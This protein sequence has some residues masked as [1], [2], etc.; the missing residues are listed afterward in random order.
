[1]SIQVVWDDDSQGCVRY[2]IRGN[3]TMED[4]DG[5]RCD[6]D[7]LTGGQHVALMIII[8][9]RES[10][11]VPNGLFAHFGGRDY[12]FTEQLSLMVFVGAS[13]LVRTLASSYQRIYRK[14][15]VDWRFAG[16]LEEARELIHAYQEAKSSRLAARVTTPAR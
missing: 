6:L 5:A 4:L 3:W 10:Q 15:A 16:N 9:V 8:D 11:F 2:D 7:A 13:S 12:S 1:M 14:R